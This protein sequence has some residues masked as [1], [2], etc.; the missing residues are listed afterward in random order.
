M[1]DIVIISAICI[2]GIAFLITNRT[3][4]LDDISIE[5]LDPITADFSGTPT[6]GYNPLTVQFTDASVNTCNVITS[7]VGDVI[8]D[9]SANWV[10]DALIGKYIH[11][12]SGTNSGKYYQITDNGT[13]WVGIY[14]IGGYYTK[15]EPPLEYFPG[16]A[17]AWDDIW[18]NTYSDPNTPLDGHWCESSTI[19]TRVGI[20]FNGVP[21]A[22]PIY[23]QA[24]ITG[25]ATPITGHLQST[26]A[27]QF[28][29]Q[30][31]QLTTEWKW[32][33]LTIPAGTLHWTFA[34]YVDF[35]AGANVR[36][37]M[38]K[39]SQSASF[40]DMGFSTTD[41]FEIVDSESE[42][43]YTITDWA[44]TFGDGETST[45][46]NPEHIYSTSGV[47]DV[48]LTASNATYSGTEL[49]S[50]YITVNDVPITPSQGTPIISLSPARR[51][52]GISV[53]GGVTPWGP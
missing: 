20:A 41:L 45:E 44:W 48:Q 17:T 23:F 51:G 19:Q 15:G 37:S 29:D 46:Q 35:I 9:S 28:P 47:Y 52:I 34:L 10:A 12:V 33:S 22:V 3:W 7:L 8:T 42:D 27:H 31:I 26:F 53:V 13:D 38:R 18:G 49:K 16:W 32:Y 14:S 40:A 43:N 30:D 50:D 4:Y 24:K 5:Y 21:D 25:V 2:I 36:L 6:S 39:I 1:I 11:V